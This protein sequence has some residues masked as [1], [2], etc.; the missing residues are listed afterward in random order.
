MTATLSTMLLPGV[1][2]ISEFA[3]WV[4]SLGAA[5]MAWLF[6]SSGLVVGVGVG[7]V[8]LSVPWGSGEMRLPVGWEE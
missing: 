3:D 7:A 1:E 8:W 4:A 5:I 2:D 6:T